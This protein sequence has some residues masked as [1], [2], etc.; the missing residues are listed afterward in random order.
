M[1]LFNSYIFRIL[2]LTVLFVSP[3][4][5]TSYDDTRNFEISKNLDIFYS[6]FQEINTHYVDEIDPGELMSY[7]IEKMLESLDPYTT[8]IPES[9]VERFKMMTKGEYGG[10]GAMIGKRDSV[11]MISEIFEG[12]PAY[13]AGLLPGDIIVSVENRSIIGKSREEIHELLQGQP[14]T[15]LT[16]GVQRKGVQQTKSVSIKRENINLKSVPYYGF[17]D[18]SIGYIKLNQFTQ[19]CAAEVRS[20]CNDLRTKGAT[21]LILDLR[22]NPGGLLLEAIQITNL[23]VAQNKK[24]V[25]TKGKNKIA[26]STFYTKDVPWDTNIP[27]VVLVNQFSASASEIVSGALQD[28]D[29]AVVVGN[30]TFGKGLVQTR[31][32]LAHN[33][34]LK[35]TTSKYYIPS[36][37]C[38][39]KMDYSNHS[40]R[41]KGVVFADSLHK[42][43]FTEN[44]RPVEDG[45]GVIPDIFVR[46]DTNTVLVKALKNE[47]VFDDFVNSSFTFADTSHV[48]ILSFT[49]DESLYQSFR[50]FASERKFTYVSESEKKLQNVIAELKRENISANQEISELQKKITA[51]QIALYTTEK[52]Y[53]KQELA[54]YI[55]L[56]L[57][58]ERGKIQYNTLHDD[59]VSQATRILQQPKEYNDIL[60]GIRGVHKKM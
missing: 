34:L 53:I 52:E 54:Q 23:F 57:Y 5:L 19:N 49:V 39:Q 13:K 26:E 20:A 8:Y 2:F 45:G 32:D 16:L 29:R 56:R 12:S 28:L 42:I 22:D 30:Q 35:V 18:K 7:T 17:I 25:Y 60:Q 6:I 10:I 33:S 50:T 44:K 36:G 58:F 37:R 40:Y 1:K 55:M 24:I 27:L 48:R 47:Y 3:L 9:D 15:T 59:Y 4:L 38:I 11:M 41:G 21:S 31:K 14:G 51:S 43:F 46:I